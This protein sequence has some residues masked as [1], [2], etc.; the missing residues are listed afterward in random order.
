[1][2]FQVGTIDSKTSNGTQQYSVLSDQP[3]AMIFFG[4]D[5]TALDTD[6]TPNIIWH[7]VT[8]G[9]NDGHIGA[10]ADGAFTA[11]YTN[12]ASCVHDRDRTGTTIMEATLS[13]WDASSF[14]LNFTTSNATARKIHYIAVS[15][16][17]LTNAHVANF[18]FGTGSSNA[19]TGPG[20]QPDFLYVIAR[21]AGRA[22]FSV[23]VSR[24]TASA[25]EFSMGFRWRSSNANRYTAIRSNSQL[26]TM[27][28]DSAI[29]EQYFSLTSFDTNGY[30]IGRDSGDASNSDFVVLALKGGDYGVGRFDSPATAIDETVSG[31]GFDPEGYYL[32][33]ADIAGTSPINANSV[34]TFYGAADGTNEAA[35]WHDVNG[36]SG[37]DHGMSDTKVIQMR[38][39]AA[40]LI[41]D[42]DHGSLGTGQFVVAYSTAETETNEVMYWA[43]RGAAAAG[44][45]TTGY[46]GYFTNKTNIVKTRNV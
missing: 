41:E 1:M 3:V 34:P 23:G 19:Q 5:C 10:A 33:G 39:E 30:T 35:L 27:A 24:G 31:L 16:S 9:T 18:A 20:F 17:E 21:K 38:T 6:T 36:T 7:G 25:D 12:S 45:D 2:A 11:G 37:E 42:A 28:D 15:G 14:T 29:D 13:A 44:G 46:P 4:G 22:G 8:D 43:F 32:Q 40:A 26:A